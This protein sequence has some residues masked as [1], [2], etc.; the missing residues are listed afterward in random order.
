MKPRGRRAKTA[1]PET[2]PRDRLVEAT[3]NLMVERGSIDVSLADIARRAD[4]NS[5]LISYYFGN[6]AGLMMELLRSVLGG[7]I[8][9][10]DAFSQRQLSPEEK[11]SGF[12]RGMIDSYFTYPFINPLTHQLVTEEPETYG[13]LIA[14]EFSKRAATILRNILAEGQASGVFAKVD[15]LHLYFHIVGACDQFFHGRYQM[16]HI[17]GIGAIDEPMK[18]GYS[19]YLANAVVKSLR[20]AT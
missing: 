14:E 3:A 8:S 4:L 7:D 9:K 18:Q 11:L 5:A 10:L 19:N 15:P 16:Q 20:P 6:K 17:F 1:E 12:V 13:P 2:P